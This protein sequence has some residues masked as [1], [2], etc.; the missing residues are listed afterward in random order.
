MD[1]WV[2]LTHPLGPA[3]S[4][5]PPFPRGAPRILHTKGNASREKRWWKTG[6]DKLASHSLETEVCLSPNSHA[7]SEPILELEGFLNTESLKDLPD[8]R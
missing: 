3:K 4:T 6:I 2:L 7:S 5:T 1:N 8:M